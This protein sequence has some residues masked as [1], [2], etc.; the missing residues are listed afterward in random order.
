ML[1]SDKVALPQ[2][3]MQDKASQ[4]ISTLR[5]VLKLPELSPADL[6]RLSLA[7]AAIAAEE[8]EVNP[9]FAQKIFC[10]Y[11]ASAPA[12]KKTLPK[13]SGYTGED[14]VPISSAVGYQINVY[15][16][17]DPETLVKIFGKEQL[18]KV[19]SLFR[20]AKLKET[21]AKL[22]EEHPGTKPRTRTKT[23]DLIAYIVSQV[24]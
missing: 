5:K 17:P 18:P 9:E 24:S 16:P 21:V 7:I 3:T 19:L 23:E 13:K 8:A 14:L 12:Q 15:G 20:P 2:P 6:K 22:M 10:L 4:A 11:E 1:V